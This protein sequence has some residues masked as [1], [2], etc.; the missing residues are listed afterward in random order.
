MNDG[1]GVGLFTVRPDGTDL[2]RVLAGLAEEYASWSPDG[3][4]ILFG[5]YGGYVVRP[6]GS[7]LRRLGVG[8]SG[9]HSWSP[10]GS[11][12][13]VFD[14]ARGIFIIARDGTDP[15]LVVKRDPD[16]SAPHSADY[17]SASER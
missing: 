11:R 8:G 1:E 16:I 2:R 12:I 17:V 13:A 14:P 4:E 7:G 6:D 3:S 5:A 10:G 15:R 9:R